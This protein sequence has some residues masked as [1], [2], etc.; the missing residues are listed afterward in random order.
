MRET[1]AVSSW[2][3]PTGRT[4]EAKTN[5]IGVLLSASR[6]VQLAES[7]IATA[8]SALGKCGLRLP[9]AAKRIRRVVDRR[10]LEFVC[11]QL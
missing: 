11:A 10:P 4:F 9:L 7:L 2:A 5:E 6:K 8:A 1:R 3:I